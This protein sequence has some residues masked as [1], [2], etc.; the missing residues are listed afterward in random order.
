[1]SEAVTNAIIHAYG[2]D[3]NAMITL[4]CEA[5]DGVMGRV[6]AELYRLLLDNLVGNAL[7]YGRENGHVDVSLKQHGDSVELTV[8]DDGAG[9]AA[10]DLPHIWEMFYRAD[11]SRSTRGLGLGLPLVRQ[12]A[13]YHGG[14]VHVESEL[15]AG[16]VFRVTIPTHGAEYSS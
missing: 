2:N 11:K 7:R 13:A 15:G 6:N 9:I 12:I 3:R 16:S 5:P 10:E 4:R 14:A 1:M 8:R